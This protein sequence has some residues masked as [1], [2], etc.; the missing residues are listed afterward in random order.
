[1]H[2]VIVFQRV[3]K[4]VSNCKFLDSSQAQ[5]DSNPRPSDVQLFY[6]LGYRVALN[7]SLIFSTC[8]L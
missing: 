1:M 8:S 6:H 7:G 2:A 3:D 5:R 4:K